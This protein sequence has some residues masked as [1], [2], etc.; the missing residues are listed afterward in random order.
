VEV[1]AKTEL[2]AIEDPATVCDGSLEIGEGR[3]AQMIRHMRHGSSPGLMAPQP[4][5]RPNRRESLATPSAGD[6][7]IGHGDP[8]VSLT[9]RKALP[10]RGGVANDGVGSRFM[11][12][13]GMS[14][15]LRTSAA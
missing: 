13:S 3:E 2:M 15:T 6:R 1:C 8:P 14:D 10:P 12:Q 7:I 9:Q 4:I 5:L 11:S